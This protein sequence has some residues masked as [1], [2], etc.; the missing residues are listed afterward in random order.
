MAQGFETLDALIPTF[1]G[2]ESPKQMVRALTDYLYQQTQ[3][4][5]FMLSNLNSNN[6]NK[7]DL[8]A[9]QTATAAMV[10]A[11]MSESIK[12]LQAELS[13]LSTKV[14]GLSGNMEN[15]LK[16][17]QADG[18]GGGSIGT[19]GKRLDLTGEVHINGKKV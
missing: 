16:T 18:E 4:L 2:N 13:D 6:W 5:Q 8:D 19:E 11:D 7:K 17:I 1:T 12:K 10:T 3:E 9:F 15:L 14:S